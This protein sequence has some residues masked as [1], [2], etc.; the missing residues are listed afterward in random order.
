MYL[1]KTHAAAAEC[2]RFRT[3]GCAAQEVRIFFFFLVVFLV[4]V[5]EHQTTADHLPES[6]TSVKL[7]NVD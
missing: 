6:V 2:R 1:A 5:L 4:V 3:L 7:K